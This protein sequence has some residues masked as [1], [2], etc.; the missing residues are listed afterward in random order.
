MGGGVGGAG[1][2][3]LPTG[4]SG[5]AASIAGGETAIATTGGELNELAQQGHKVHESM[6]LASSSQGWSTSS[7]T[8]PPRLSASSSAKRVVQTRP[9][10]PS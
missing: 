3:M 1:A 10:A 2:S 5:G 4:S 8:W 7:T 9:T 6:K